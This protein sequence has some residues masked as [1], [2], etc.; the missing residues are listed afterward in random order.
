M[1][2][3]GNNLYFDAKLF[4][5]PALHDLLVQLYGKPLSILNQKLSA[6][7]TPSGTPV[8]LVICSTHT[9]PYKTLYLDT[10]ED[11]KIW[12]YVTK[13]L[14]IPYLDLNEEMTALNV[15]YF[16]LTENQPVP[17]AG[18]HFNPEGHLFFSMLLVH[19][20]I[21][22]GLIPWNRPAQSPRPD[23]PNR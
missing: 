16:P 15:S 7:R 11:P 6:M 18:D 8:R 14:G 19:D 9:R 12:A 23:Q 1:K 2:V 21:R 17:V 3:N 20:L 13:N 4:E 5:E 10:T 22:D